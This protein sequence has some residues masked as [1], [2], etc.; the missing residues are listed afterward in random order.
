[1]R[2]FH[3]LTGV[4]LEVVLRGAGVLP[5]LISM[6]DVRPLFER[7]SLLPEQW[8]HF[9]MLAWDGALLAAERAALAQPQTP[10]DNH[11]GHSVNTN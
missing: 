1:M 2:T 5:P 9:V 8:R 7:L 3:R 11:V 10:H 6:D 4:P